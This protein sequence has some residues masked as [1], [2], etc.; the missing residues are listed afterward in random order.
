MSLDVTK[1]KPY[2]VFELMARIWTVHPRKEKA[3]NDEKWRELLS[4]EDE[5]ALEEDWL[6]VGDDLANAMI[7]ICSN[8]LSDDSASRAK[9]FAGNLS[10][11][12][13]RIKSRLNLVGSVRSQ[14]AGS[15]A[16]FHAP[17]RYFYCSDTSCLKQKFEPSTF[18]KA[19]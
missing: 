3:F 11:E 1:K 2:S 19:T 6:V 9:G 14:P 8:D 12:R 4:L 16:L 13:D 17:V 7:V 15:G 5:H 18:C 10:K